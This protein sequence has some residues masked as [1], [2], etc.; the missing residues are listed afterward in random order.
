MITKGETYRLEG[1][2]KKA[3]SEAPV[4]FRCHQHQ[5]QPQDEDTE[6]QKEL[7]IK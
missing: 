3:H 4:L 7:I 5:E 6:L 2:R 1:E